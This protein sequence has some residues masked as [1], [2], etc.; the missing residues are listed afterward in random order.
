MTEKII[1]ALRVF[2]SDESGLDDIGFIDDN[3]DLIEAG[4]LDSLL[5][6]ML[7]SFCEEEFNKTIDLEDVTDENFRSLNTIAEY[8]LENDKIG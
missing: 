8:V 6:V 1:A 2:I 3:T 5:M 4:V 7:V